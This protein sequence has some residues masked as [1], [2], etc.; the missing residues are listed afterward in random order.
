MR[1]APWERGADPDA[2][3]GDGP[4]DGAAEEETESI[5]SD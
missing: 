5:C 3:P 4:D 1:G 2:D